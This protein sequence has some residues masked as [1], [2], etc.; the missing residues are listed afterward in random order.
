MCSSGPYCRNC[1]PLSPGPPRGSSSA[2]SGK[3]VGADRI[4]G[5]NIND[6]RKELTAKFGRS[7]FV[8]PNDVEGDPV[9]HLVELTGG[10]ADYSFECVGFV[11]LMARGESIRRVVMY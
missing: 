10:G 7:N 5:V 8:N 3:I 1:W 6:D 9:A 4:I 2:R 11:N